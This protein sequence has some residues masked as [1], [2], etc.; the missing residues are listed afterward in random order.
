LDSNPAINSYYRGVAAKKSKHRQVI[1]RLFFG[2]ARIARC[3]VSLV[4]VM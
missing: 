2:P 4:S 3:I 1:E